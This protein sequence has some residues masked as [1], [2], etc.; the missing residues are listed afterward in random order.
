[1]YYEVWSILRDGPVIIIIIIIIII[2]ITF[3]HGIYKDTPVTNHVSTV[4]T[5]LQLLCIYNL[6]YM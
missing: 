4:Y 2:V 3:M 1:V 5:V 6:C